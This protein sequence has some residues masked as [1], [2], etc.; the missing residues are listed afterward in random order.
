MTSNGDLLGQVIELVVE[1]MSFGAAA[2]ARYQLPGQLKPVVV[3]VR[4]GAPGDRLRARVHEVHKN[5][6][7]AE[8]LEVITPGPGRREAPCL[9]FGKCGGCQWQHLTYAAQLEAK[10]DV[11]LHQLRKLGKVD[12]ALAE[13]NLTVH[14]AENEFGYRVRV[15]ARGNADGLGFY[16]AGS[17]ELVMTDRCLVA[18]TDIEAA[19][20]AFLAS[21]RH[22]ELAKDAAEFKVEWQRMPDGSVATSINK[23]HAALGFTQVNEAQNQVLV[24]TVA[25]EARTAQGRGLLLDL[26]GGRG[27]LSE[28][29]KPDFSK[30][31]CV[32]SHN[33]G[34]PIT[35]IRSASPLGNAVFQGDV[36]AFLAGRYWQDSSHKLTEVDCVIADPPRAGLGA[37]SQAIL[38]LKATKLI[39]VSCDPSTFC[40]D[41]GHFLPAYQLERLHLVDMFPQTYHM[42]IIAVL[43]MR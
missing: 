27:N 5:Y 21:G 10:R 16:R 25:G 1:R 24:R 42:E 14:P 39:L 9:V 20:S 28:A 29:L 40:R 23:R 6:W 15:Q 2:V 38:S 41:L 31:L 7:E 35:Q 12:L 22:Q 33:G 43:A 19:W 8:L 13:A 26:Y 32:D 18:H 11:L 3:F 36:E 37:A 30:V 17:R 4:G 34:P